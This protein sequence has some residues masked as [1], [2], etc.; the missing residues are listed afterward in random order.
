MSPAY[1]AERLPKKSRFIALTVNTTEFRKN[2]KHYM[3]LSNTEDVYVTSG[4]KV[5]TVLTSPVA[6]DLEIV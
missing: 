3:E 1:P 5:L 6:K 4:G 2:L